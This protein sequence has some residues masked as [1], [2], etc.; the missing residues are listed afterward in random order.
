MPATHSHRPRARRGL[1]ALAALTAA[2]APAFAT[3]APAFATGAPASAHGAHASAQSAPASA[4]AAP[5]SNQATIA[6]GG[7]AWKRLR[8]LGVRVEAVKPARR[9]GSRFVLPVANLSPLGSDSAAVSHRGALKLRSGRRTLTLRGFETVAGPR[10]ELSAKAGGRRVVLFRVPAKSGRRT[11]DATTG[12]VAVSGARLQL[13]PA[14]GQLLRQRLKL[15]T[16][17]TGTFGTLR[18]AADTTVTGMPGFASVDGPPTPGGAQLSARPATAVDVVGG[19][20]RWSPRPSWLG[21]LAQGGGATG[22]AGASF[23]DGAFALPIAS[24]WYD[25]ASG[26]AVVQTSGTTRFQYLDHQIDVALADWAF[27]LGATPKATT[28]VATALHAVILSGPS[29]VGTRQ[30]LFFLGDRP[31]AVERADGRAV[32]W[33][34]LPATLTNEGIALYLV[35]PYRSDQGRVSIDAELGG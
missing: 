30:P 33:S 24:G 15:S 11:L 20:V 22:A 6:L 32:S 18:L 7:P 14:G 17:V 5:T 28:T 1:L 26:H 23:A 25:R 10:A 8:T 31:A 34:D 3:T 4:A 21:Y 2:S 9:S 27:D 16:R 19:T 29:I 35:Y 12:A 13:T